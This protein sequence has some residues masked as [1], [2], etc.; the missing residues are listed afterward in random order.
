MIGVFRSAERRQDL[1]LAN[2]V[3]IDDSRFVDEE[4]AGDFEIIVEFSLG[5][6]PEVG[7]IA[8]A[9]LLPESPDELS[10]SA[11]PDPER[12]RRVVERSVRL[13]AWFGSLGT[14][15]LGLALVVI[16]YS[17]GF[18]A[19]YAEFGLRFALGAPFLSVLVQLVFEILLLTTIAAMTGA[20][21]GILVV[22]S[23]AAGRG[24]DP[25]LDVELTMFGLSATVLGAVLFALP[26]AIYASRIPPITALRSGRR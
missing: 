11:V 18:A 8:P 6:G 17:L 5:S 20:V 16:G 23:V 21:V 24:V 15:V 22:L 26:P 1:A 12:F 10:V 19:R 7:Q 14:L 25:V 4:R 2:L 3:P 13:V 9:A